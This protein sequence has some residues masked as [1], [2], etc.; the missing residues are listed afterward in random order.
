MSRRPWEL[1]PDS[2][3]ILSP[4]LVRSRS[5]RSFAEHATPSTSSTNSTT[6]TIAVARFLEDHPII[7]VIESAGVKLR[8]ACRTDGGEWAGPCPLCGGRDRLRVWPNPES[9]HPRAW[10]R[11]CLRAGDALDWTTWM[12]GRAPHVHGGVAATLL[13]HGYLHARRG[14]R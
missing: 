7:N 1:P 2:P 8:R 3:E 14:V 11:Q 12:A 10:C 6:L 13:E 9:G 4:H 5:E